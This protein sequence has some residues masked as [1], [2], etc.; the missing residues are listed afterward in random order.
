MVFMK[1]RLA[2]IIIC[3]HRGSL[4]SAKISY[5]S[6]V[7]AELLKVCFAIVIRLLGTGIAVYYEYREQDYYVNS[8]VVGV[9]KSP[10]DSGLITMCRAL[11]C[12]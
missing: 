9:Q 4:T 7:P 8:P 2:I 6:L 5:S 12:V 1:Q 3:N 10:W 11:N